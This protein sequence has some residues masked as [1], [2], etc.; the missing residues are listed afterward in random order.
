MNGNA[1]QIVNLRI[2]LL[3]AMARAQFNIKLVGPVE[4]VFAGLITSELNVVSYE[5]NI[6][7]PDEKNEAK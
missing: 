2:A 4:H 5:L 6:L 7:L 3:F 1:L